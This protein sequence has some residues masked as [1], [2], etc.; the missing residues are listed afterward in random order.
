MG[1]VISRGSRD[2]PKHFIKYRE[3]D[4]TQRMRLSKQ[5][6]KSLAKQLLADVESRVAR[7]LPAFP[8]EGKKTDSKAGELLDAFK[9]SMSNRNADDDRSRLDRHLKPRFEKMKLAEIDLAAVMQWIDDMKSGKARVFD[10]AKDKR[11]AAQLSG[12]SMRQNVNLLSRFFSWAIERGHAELNPVRLIP[13][14]KRPTQAQKRD[15]PWLDDD[16]IVRKLFGQLRE[17][18]N[19]M[20]YLG[21]RSGLRLGE[22][23]GLR[24]SDFAFL[25][26][27][28]IRVRY[29]YDG[30][31]LK[32]DKRCE[33]KIKWVPAPADADVVLADWRAQRDAEGAGPEDLLFP[34][35]HRD[36]KSYHKLFIERAWEDALEHFNEAARK[37]NEKAEPLELT[38]YQATR[39]SF[40]SRTLFKGASLEE[41]SA[42]V[43]HS[44]PEVT[45][46]YYDHFVRQS[47]SP[48]LREG[49]GIAP[50][51]GSGK[52]LQMPKARRQKA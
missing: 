1:S 24:I 19:L 36:G 50:P 33:G 51:K 22:L 30:E 16:A 8:N 44:S 29:Q 15:Q 3:A 2:N 7:G 20:F 6:T 9:E 34:N 46:R 49:L 12:A 38:F 45:K 27:G 13:Q 18:V 35:P 48:G 52:V 10:R 40:V 5:P 25:E 47:F 26:K 4:G 21:N 41:V 14:G 42:A 43:G 31:F 23:C 39:H 28:V 32:E 37:E 17:P 11:V